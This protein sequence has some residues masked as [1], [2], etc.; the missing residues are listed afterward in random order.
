MKMRNRIA[1]A[2]FV[3]LAAISFLWADELKQITVG[4]LHSWFSSSGNEREASGPIG[5]QID[6]LDYPALYRH[7]DMQ[8]AKAV[9]IGARNYNDPIVNKVYDYKVV[10]NGPRKVDE[11]AGFIP[12]DFTLYGRFEKPLVLVDGM[13]AGAIQFTDEVDIIDENL[14]VDRRL[15]NIVNTSMGIQMKRVISY[16]NHPDYNNFMVHEYTFTNNGVYNREGDVNPNNTLQELWFFYQ[17][18]YGCAKDAAD[19]YLNV[20]PRSAKWGRNQMNDYIFSP[21]RAIISWNG[22]HH[23]TT[24][25]DNLGAPAVNTDGHLASPHFS[26]V[27]VLH[28]D[29]SASQST[30]DP[31]QPKTSH[32]IGSNDPTNT[33]QE[34]F[35]EALM[36]NQYLKMSAGHPTLTHAQDVEAS[37]KAPSEWGDDGGGYSGAFGFGP[38]EMSNGDSLRIVWADG[39]GVISR[40]KAYEV[41]HNWLHSTGNYLL[42][43]GGSTSDRD[44]Y[45]NAWVFT[46]RDSLLKFFGKATELY[47]NGFETP[48]PPDPP[49]WFEVQSGGDRVILKWESNAESQAHF[50]G[51][52]IYRA[53]MERD[54]TYHLIYECGL[55]TNEAV[56][57]EYHDK[58]PQRGFDYYYY[59]ETFDDGWSGQTL[60]SSKFYTLT[61]EPAYLRRPARDDLQ[62]IRIVPNPYN[63]RAKHL[64]YGTGDGE[65]RIMFLNLPPYCTIDIYTERGDLIKTIDHFDATGDEAWNQ[66]SSSRQNIVSGIYIAHITTPDGRSI[67]KKFMIIR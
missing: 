9:W 58:T 19:Y 6:G 56:V 67:N 47:K 10:G 20:V 61:A 26:G 38:Y 31:E 44:E 64:Q 54:S 46:G 59:I 28:A 42:P 18:R 21:Y 14:P 30:D 50:G 48:L 2:C 17:Y 8:A 4:D 5:T 15:V 53:L 39:V 57:N 13:T 29:K 37:G 22:R 62:E 16:T 65:D 1:A 34:Q 49:S 60:S 51:Y 33:P 32:Y 24:T 36:T 45:K 25:H 63:I 7:Q 52:R 23:E 27:V 35:N 55:G 66:V 11:L 3:I 43:D 41:G 40:E 12:Q